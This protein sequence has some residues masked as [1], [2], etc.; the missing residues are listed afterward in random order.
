MR[1]LILCTMLGLAACATNPVT[2]KSQLSLVSEAQEIEM[3]RGELTRAR[4]ESGF[5]AD[6][7]LEQYVASIGRQMAAA[8]ERPNLPWEFH[9]IDDP[10]VN[11]FAAPGGFVFVTRGILGYLNSEAELAAVLGHEIGHVTAKHT[12]AMISQQQLAQVGLI[13]GSIAAPEGGVRDR[14]PGRRQR[15]RHSTS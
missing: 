2:G 10:M 8:S 7:A 3:G 14:R 1:Y 13:A 5:V 6:A 4:Q 11:A 15:R 12:V 9:V